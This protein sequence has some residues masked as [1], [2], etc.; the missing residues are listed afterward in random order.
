MK[1]AKFVSGVFVVLFIA[2]LMLPRLSAYDKNKRFKAYNPGLEP[3]S[4]IHQML[5]RKMKGFTVFHNHADGFSAL[6]SRLC[7]KPLVGSDN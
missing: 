5:N 1:I 6:V 7:I 2:T 3:C 4:E